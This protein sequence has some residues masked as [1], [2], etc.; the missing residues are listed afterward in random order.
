MD[1]RQYNTLKWLLIAI[2][3]LMVINT[4]LFIYLW[5]RDFYSYLKDFIEILLPY[6][7]RA[8]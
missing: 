2:L 4:F 3:V 6:S 5:P 7:S 8:M 1:K